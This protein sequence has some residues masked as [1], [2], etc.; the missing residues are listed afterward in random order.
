MNPAGTTSTTFLLLLLILPA[1]PVL[2]QPWF[3]PRTGHYCQNSTCEEHGV[4]CIPELPEL[5]ATLE[6]LSLSGHSA[7]KGRVPALA[8]IN[9]DP[10]SRADLIRAIRNIH[11]PPRNNALLVV[12]KPAYVMS[13]LSLEV[14]DL[15]RK[16]TL[17]GSLPCRYEQLREE[18]KTT[19]KEEDFKEFGQRFLIAVQRD[20][21]WLFLNVYVSLD[22]AVV[23]FDHHSCAIIYSQ[24]RVFLQFIHEFLHALDSIHIVVYR[25]F[26]W[27]PL[28][29][30]DLTDLCSQSTAEV[31]QLDEFSDTDS[32][33]PSDLSDAED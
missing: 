30:E 19:F 29:L 5:T 31:G 22:R 12:P 10:V 2:G 27:L 8:C 6:S 17:Y 3:C 18:M 15:R 13:G 28:R 14:D 1:H 7:R 4:T 33:D 11:Y 24:Y 9:S 16:N 20:S 32:T 26:P 23:W 21:N 25:H